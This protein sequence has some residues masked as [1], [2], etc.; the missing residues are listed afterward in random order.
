MIYKYKKPPEWSTDYPHAK[1]SHRIQILNSSMNFI[2][3]KLSSVMCMWYCSWSVECVGILYE[4]GMRVQSSLRNIRKNSPRRDTYPSPP[5]YYD[6]FVRCDSL[7]KN[8][9]Y[10][11]KVKNIPF[12]YILKNNLFRFR[13]EKRMKKLSI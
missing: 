8:S 2:K 12:F 4:G 13:I 10:F 5:P 6:Y 7:I 1:I 3:V 11:W 9:I